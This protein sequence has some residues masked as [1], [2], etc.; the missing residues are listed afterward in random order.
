MKA[1]VRANGPPPTMAAKMGV[2]KQ[3]APGRWVRGFGLPP[4]LLGYGAADSHILGW[5]PAP[6]GQRKAPRG[7]S[8]PRVTANARPKPGSGRAFGPPRARSRGGPNSPYF[9]AK[10]R[11]PLYRPNFGDRT[12]KILPAFFKVPSLK[13]LFGQLAPPAG[14]CYNGRP[15]LANIFRSVHTKPPYLGMRLEEVYA[16]SLLRSPQKPGD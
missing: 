2:K 13:T 16:L 9:S 7:G 3:D 11:L 6:E 10:P 14:L 1:L 4:P 5:L 12:A 8:D 15:S